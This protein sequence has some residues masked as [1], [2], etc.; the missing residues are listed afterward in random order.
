MT[1]PG[2]IAAYRYADHD[3]V[4]L[5]EEAPPSGGRALLAPLWRGQRPVEILDARTALERAQRT[6]KIERD[7]L[8]ANVRR[9]DEPAVWPMVASDA[10]VDLIAA[11]V[12]EAA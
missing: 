6:A 7:A 10:L 5:D 8:P 9:L 4:T 2:R 12:K 11:R 1:L 3:L